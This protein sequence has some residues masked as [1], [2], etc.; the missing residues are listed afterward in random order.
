[1]RLAENAL[2]PDL[3][4]VATYD[5]NSIGSR[6][7]GADTGSTGNAFRNLASDHFNDWSLGLRLNV[8]IGYR[9][10]YANVRIAKLTLARDYENL[11][12]AGTEDPAGA[13]PSPTRR[14]S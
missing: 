11:R 3:R 2:L 4:F 10:A 1:M 5:V 13:R 9:N 8:P 7:D 14:C 6:I 12:D